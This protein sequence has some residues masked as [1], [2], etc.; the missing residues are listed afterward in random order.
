M[1]LPPPQARCPAAAPSSGAGHGAWRGSPGHSLSGVCAGR[2]SCPTD[3]TARSGSPKPRTGAAKDLKIPCCRLGHTPAWTQRAEPWAGDMA[4]LG[5][6]Q[7][8]RSCGLEGHEFLPCLP[9]HVQNS[10]VH[11]EALRV[12]PGPSSGGAG[13]LA[14]REGSGA[15][16]TL[17]LPSVY[18][19]SQAPLKQDPALLTPA[20]GRVRP[21]AQAAQGTP[22]ASGHG[23]SLICGEHCWLRSP[24][25]GPCPVQERPVRLEA[26]R[27]EGWVRHFSA[28]G[29]AGPR[30]P[31]PQG[32]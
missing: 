26:R 29:G 3:R 1:P 9:G 20:R 15:A 4:W 24:A 31:A 19:S 11:T 8:G 18:R 32:Q 6:R 16:R 22:T 17:G 14:A 25:A 12:V 21:A 28:R 10:D 23:R 7:G 27:W 30:P 13:P 2:S 5:C